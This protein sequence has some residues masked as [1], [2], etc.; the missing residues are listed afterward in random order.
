MTAK[1]QILVVAALACLAFA[2]SNSPPADAKDVAAA[3][4]EAL[5]EEKPALKE[6]ELQTSVVKAHLDV[7]KDD[8]VAALKNPG[9]WA[10]EFEKDV[11]DLVIGLSKGGFGATPFG[12]SVEKISNIIKK[13]MMPQVVKF[14]SD[15]QNKLNELA[16]EWK[17]CA[18][19][20]KEQLAT[21]NQRKIKYVGSSKSHKVCRGAEA[22]LYTEN[23]E[24]HEEW[25]SRKKEKELKCKAYAEISKKYGDSNANKQIVTK[26]GSEGVITYVTRFTTIICGQPATCPTCKNGGGGNTGGRGGLCVG[27]FLDMLIC[28]KKK[29]EVA[30][31]RYNEQTRKCKKLDGQWHDKRKEC[32]SIQDTM[33]GHA[34]KWA[35]ESKDACESYAECHKVNE[36]EY[37]LLKT[38][39][40]K[41]EPPRHAEWKGLKRMD[42]IIKAFAGASGISMADILRCKNQNHSTT[43][44]GENVTGTTR[45]LTILYPTPPPLDACVVP[46][47]Y[48]NTAEYK[49]AE[50]APLPTLAK[51][52]AGANECTGVGA[53]STTPAPGSPASCKCERVT[54]NGPYSSGSLV[55]CTNCLDVRKSLDKISCPTGTKLFSPQSR[56]D[57]DSFLKSAAP[58]RAP[59]WIIDVT[60]PQNGCGGCTSH[61]MMSQ[62]TEQKSWVT[63]DASPWWLR[64]TRYSEPNGDYSANCYLDLWRTPANSNSVTWNDGNCNYHSK[65]YYCQMG[66]FSVTPKVGSP[67]ACTCKKVELVGRYSAR[68]LLK[69]ENCLDVRRSK[70]KN[71][72]PYGTKLFSPET[73]EDWKT[74]IRS[75]TQ[76]RAPHWIIDITRPTNG[77]GGCTKNAM[78]SGVAAQGTW[79][80]ADNSPWWLR[81]T[82]YNEPNGDYS[83]NCYL[84]LWH[85]PPN[86]NSVT[87]NDGNCNYHSKSYY[88]QSVKAKKNPITTTLPPWKVKE[89]WK[90]VLKTNGDATFGFSSAYWTNDK[91]LNPTASGAAEG[92]AKYPAFTKVPF[93]KIRMCVGK[94][95]TNCVEHKFNRDYANAKAL[96]AAD[97][98]RDTT[99]D[100]T[101]ILK[102]FGPKA[103]AYQKCPPQRPGFNIQCNDGNKARWGYC[104]NCQSQ[105]CQN[106]DT[107]D[108]DAAIGIGLAGQSTPAQ[109]GAGWTNYF[110]SGK[111]TCSANSMTKKQV[112]FYVFQNLML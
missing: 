112:W 56:Q 74:F 99:L 45:G 94:P 33:D 14:H 4:A 100:Q 10:S 73:R 79:V 81:K 106:S 67:K 60:R 21:A 57:W 24:C 87:W 49:A 16:T 29:C 50:F 32:N 65:S 46:L 110:A 1:V 28:H 20:R 18:A 98:I 78:N 107:N 82:T 109:M 58:L 91:T 83:A 42:C 15:D 44:G 101:G 92:N 85:N 68:V 95:D 72:C 93:S 31:K 102:V 35:I 40:L 22:A 97:Y 63:K 7:S 80:T 39:V 38:K 55:K 36:A 70:D 47:L 71:S 17:S 105:P 12:K 27:G 2:A 111:G 86:E 30:T 34:C 41:D 76:L 9:G 108:A 43:T 11:M 104:T 54:M 5:N 96:F 37:A 66:K 48:P 61:T 53:I 26:M 84:D 19:T 62:T 64:S 77:C 6:E 25:L 8:L 13:E 89:Q 88:C 51:G 90:L 103:G 59:H 23:V 3:F 52:K 69:C 75:A